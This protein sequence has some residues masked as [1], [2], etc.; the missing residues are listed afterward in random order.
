MTE[1]KMAQSRAL[2]A[3]RAGS[4]LAMLRI[5]PVFSERRGRAQA[6]PDTL[7]VDVGLEPKETR[8]TWRDYR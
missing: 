7:R 5:S 3:S 2:K 1:W 6:V 8:R 4:I